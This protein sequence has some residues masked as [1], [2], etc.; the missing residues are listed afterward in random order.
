MDF[1]QNW[2][3]G[4][5]LEA[6]NFSP[7]S[8]YLQCEF[9]GKII[10]KIFDGMRSKVRVFVGLKIP[11]SILS[12]SQGRATKFQE[13]IFIYTERVIINYHPSAQQKKKKNQDQLWLQRRFPTFGAFR[14]CILRYVFVPSPV[15]VC[16][17]RTK[18]HKI[19]KLPTFLKILPLKMSISPSFYLHWKVDM[20]C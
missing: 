11:L 4:S 8:G 18:Y 19:P 7:A 15:F 10:N 17:L 16:F 12:W 5:D 3:K 14:F 20:S 2:W 6:N 9:P 13:H 1:F